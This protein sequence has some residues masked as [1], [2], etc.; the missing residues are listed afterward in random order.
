MRMD[1]YYDCLYP[2]ELVYVIVLCLNIES[3]TCVCDYH[4]CFYNYNFRPKKKNATNMFKINIKN[5]IY[6][7]HLTIVV[8][9]ME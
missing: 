5:S 1:L 9:G 7:N 8:L 4:H 3:S 2:Q 6:L